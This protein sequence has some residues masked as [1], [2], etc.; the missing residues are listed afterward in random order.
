MK[1]LSHFHSP[2]ADGCCLA[3]CRA[4]SSRQNTHIR[5]TVSGSIAYALGSTKRMTSLQRSSEPKS[6]ARRLSRLSP[7]SATGHAIVSNLCGGN[8]TCLGQ[9]NWSTAKSECPVI[10]AVSQLLVLPG[11]GAN[12]V[13]PVL[14][15]LVVTGQAPVA[16]CPGS[17]PWMVVVPTHRLPDFA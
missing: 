6:A 3:P 17:L 15:V 13:F 2:S 8:S 11:P 10:S 9:W 16:S 14:D 7:S 5:H 12:E 4:P 1:V